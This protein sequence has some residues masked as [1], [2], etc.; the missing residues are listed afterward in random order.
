G[1]GVRLLCL[2]KLRLSTALD[3]GAAA[4]EPV[5]KTQVQLHRGTRKANVFRLF[6]SLVAAYSGHGHLLHNFLRFT[7]QLVVVVPTS[8]YDPLVI[9]DLVGHRKARKGFLGRR[10]IRLSAQHRPRCP[11]A[12][13]DGH[14]GAAA[15]YLSSHTLARS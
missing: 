3:F 4:P 5:R 15:A 11:S 2:R 12:A 14:R 8:G 9:P 13:A 1:G 6:F 7:D 10:P